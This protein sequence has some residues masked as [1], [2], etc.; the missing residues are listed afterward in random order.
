MRNDPATSDEERALLNEIPAKNG[1]Y[2]YLQDTN[3]SV[4]NF[5]ENSVRNILSDS[6]GYYSDSVAMNVTITESIYPYL[7]VVGT[8]TRSITPPKVNSDGSTTVRFDLGDLKGGET[9]TVRIYT[10]LNLSEMPVDI[11][12]NKTRKDFS[13]DAMTPPSNMT[14]TS[15]IDEPRKVEMPEG[16]LSIFC[17]ESCPEKP[18]I[19]PSS[20]V[21]ANATKTTEP[22]D[23]SSKPQPVFE[24][25]F[26]AVVIIV[27]YLWRRW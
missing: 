20:T 6:G 13:P 18:S 17:G 19:V 24:V 23:K 15:L 21:E 12:K 11:T 2:G 4:L 1:G 9:K 7:S 14:Y 8:S 22:I 16:Q 27:A 25:A 3:P 5:V 10:A 26:A